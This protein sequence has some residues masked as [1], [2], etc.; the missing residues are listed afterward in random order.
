MNTFIR[1]IY[2]YLDAV[3]KL[4]GII[5]VVGLFL[6]FFQYKHAV[7]IAQRNERRA[8]IELAV[9][10]CTSFGSALMPQFLKLR[11]TIENS[12]CEFFKHFKLIKEENDLKPNTSSVTQDDYRI[13]DEHAEE[14]VRLLNSLEGFAIPF[15]AGVAD[16]RIGFIE[17][18]RSFVAT[19]EQLFGLYARYEL[20]HYYPST[21]TLY[22]NWRKQIARDDRRRMH[23]DLGRD[24]FALTEQIVRE[25]SDSK[26]L[27]AL[28]KKVS[29]SLMKK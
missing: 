12:G 16:G 14:T 15:A 23:L 9:R 26:M 7:R 19:F 10:E 13:L 22:W 29:N 18:G 20:K 11:T 24:F 6:A 25:E 27:K 17:C 21:Q 28:W 2:P 5:G 3:A 1:E 4:V 8:S